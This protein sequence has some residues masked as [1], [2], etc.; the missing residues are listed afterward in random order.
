VR[1]RARACARGSSDTGDLAAKRWQLPS[2]WETALDLQ[3]QSDP[4]I[5]CSIKTARSTSIVWATLMVM[6]TVMVMVMM[7]DPSMPSLVLV[8]VGLR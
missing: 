2:R 7:L 3:L 4:L 5:G 8:P 1:A 6:S